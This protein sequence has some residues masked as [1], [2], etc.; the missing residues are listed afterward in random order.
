MGFYYSGFLDYGLDNET[1][2]AI[3]K[4]CRKIMFIIC[5]INQDKR[6]CKLILYDCGIIRINEDD[7]MFKLLKNSILIFLTL[8]FCMLFTTA[9]SAAPTIQIDGKNISFD[10]PPTIE[11]GRTLVPARAILE[12]LGAEVQW[13]ENTQTLYARSETSN[14]KLTINSLDAYVNDIIIPLDVAPQIVHDRVLV[15]L[16]FVSVA[17]GS[18]VDWDDSTQLISIHMPAKQAQN[19]EEL[20]GDKSAIIQQDAETGYS[21]NVEPVKAEQQNNIRLTENNSDN[22]QAVNLQQEDTEP[23]KETLPEGLVIFERL[24]KFSKATIHEQRIISEFFRVDFSTV[25]TLENLGYTKNQSLNLAVL[26]KEYDFT[27]EEVEQINKLYPRID[28]AEEKLI[29]YKNYIT[30]NKLLTEKQKAQIKQLILEGY[31]IPQIDPS[32]KSGRMVVH[33]KEFSL[34]LLDQLNK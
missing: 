22:S 16:R 14:I 24:D 29:L 12:A 8:L 26:A 30:A 1:F 28:I 31:T 7:S 23:W 27:I 17:F 5:R 11:N 9:I 21:T 2:L 15:P 4:Y 18:Q 32:C 33:T 25:L 34:P 20:P 3:I 19:D 13:D 10:V 6:E